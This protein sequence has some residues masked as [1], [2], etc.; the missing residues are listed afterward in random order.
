MHQNENPSH[1]GR[2]AYQPPRLTVYGSMRDLT[3]GGTGNSLE[4][5]EDPKKRRP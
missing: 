4:S 3:A 2:Q 5:H 1:A